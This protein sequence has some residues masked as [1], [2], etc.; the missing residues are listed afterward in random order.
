MKLSSLLSLAGI[1]VKRKGMLDV[2]GVDRCCC[3]GGCGL[4]KLRG[5]MV[6]ERGGFRSALV[7]RGESGD[8]RVGWKVNMD[9]R[10]SRANMFVCG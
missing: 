4:G 5:D 10:V 1:E 9:G 7:C 3:G 6:V 2:W 8:G